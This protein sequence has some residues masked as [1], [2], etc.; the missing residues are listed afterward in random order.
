MKHGILKMHQIFHDS[1]FSLPL[2]IPA[3]WGVDSLQENISPH[4]LKK[5]LFSLAF[6]LKSYGLQKLY[7]DSNNSNIR[8]FSV[9]SRNCGECNW[10]RSESMYTARVYFCMQE[11][12]A[13]KVC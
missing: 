8:G 13:G 3:I 4:H 5:P 9:E 10:H 1:P 2:Y 12:V 11:S 6:I 7:Y